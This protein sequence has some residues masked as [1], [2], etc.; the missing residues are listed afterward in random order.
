MLERKHRVSTKVTAMKSY[1]IELLF[2][3]KNGDF[4]AIS[5]T[6]RNYAPPILK[7]E[8]HILVRSLRVRIVTELTKAPN[9]AQR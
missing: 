5:V 2:A 4:S 1:W 3:L 9:F 6:E 8:S 7:V